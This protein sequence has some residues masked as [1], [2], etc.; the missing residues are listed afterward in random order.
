MPHTETHKRGAYAKGYS[1]D[2]LIG[3]NFIQRYKDRELGKESIDN[4]ITGLENDWNELDDGVKKNI[5]GTANFIGNAYNEARSISPD[6][7]YNP[8]AYVEAGAVRGIEGIVNTVGKVSDFV[9]GNPARGVGWMMGLD[10]RA[11]EA[12]SIAAQIYLGPKAISKVSKLKPSNFG[13]TTKVEPY[14]PPK[15]IGK[16]DKKMIN[17]TADAVDET[18]NLNP[19]IF[20]RASKIYKANP[21]IGMKKAI[22]EAKLLEGFMPSKLITDKTFGSIK[23][24][25]L[26]DPNR[27]DTTRLMF[28]GSMG[29]LGIG[30]VGIPGL[31]ST[32]RKKITTPEFIDKRFID[33]GFTKK[34]PNGGWIF[35]EKVY[36]ARKPDGTY[37]LNDNQ[38]REIIQIF[39]TD[40]NQTV[41]QSFTKEKNIKNLAFSE[42][43]AEHNLKYGARPELHHD[44]P[45]ALSAPFYFGLEYMSDD[46]RAMT[47]IANEYGNYPG[48]PQIE[49]STNLVT[50]PSKIGSNH[51]NYFLVKEKFGNV[52]PHLHNIVHSQFFANETGMS[53]DKFFTPARVNKMNKSFED[54]ME[55]FREYNKIVA[56]NRELWTEGLNQ[57]NIFFGQVPIDYHDDLVRMLEEYLEKGMITLGKGKV[58]DRFGELVKTPDGKLAEANYAQFSV[59]DIVSNALA[60][61]KADFKNDILGKNPRFKEALTEV[62]NFSQLNQS[63]IDDMANVLYKIKQYNG[64]RLVVGTRQAGVMVFGA[65]RNVKYYNE[66]LELY[67]GLIDDALPNDTP[68]IVTLEQLKQTTFKDFVKP[69]FIEQLEIEFP[70]DG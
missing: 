4:I 27:D 59:Q 30:D 16:V 20:R 42:K 69:S 51:P 25:G 57:L 24:G 18:L 33:Y 40:I 36:N 2:E 17:I 44:F 47:A 23:K 43:F 46:W 48:Q 66:L 49:G 58:K 11:R 65:G 1:V 52:P 63:E 41:P 34:G 28:T 35:D 15:G 60:D 64:L 13:I 19:E 37:V 38:R 9:I 62:S 12:M 26:F 6:E 31:K 50:L 55:V 22:E 3:P 54:R 8:L 21:N 39:Q 7:K 14:V 68:T 67:M 56:R 61:F 53:G 32:T 10:P 5:V 70:D 45:S 29:G